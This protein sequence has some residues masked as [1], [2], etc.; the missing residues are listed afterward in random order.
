MNQDLP[1]HT[2]SD[3]R[4]VLNNVRLMDAQIPLDG[5]ESKS[6]KNMVHLPVLRAS[7]PDVGQQG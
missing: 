6:K 5:G 7:S 1:H 2:V 3:T 4:N